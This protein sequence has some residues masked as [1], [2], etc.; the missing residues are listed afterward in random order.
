VQ[1]YLSQGFP[2]EEVWD[3]M[4]ILIA[5]KNIIQIFIACL[6]RAYLQQVSTTTRSELSANQLEEKIAKNPTNNA[7]ALRGNRTPG[8]SRHTRLMATTQVTTTPLML[9]E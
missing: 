7:N 9:V 6:N 3:Y 1:L 4:N 5:C 2:N 8:G